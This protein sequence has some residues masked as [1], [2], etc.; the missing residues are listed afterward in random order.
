MYVYNAFRSDPVRDHVMC[1]CFIGFY[2]FERQIKT[3]ALTLGR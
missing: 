1:C 3:T 2:M